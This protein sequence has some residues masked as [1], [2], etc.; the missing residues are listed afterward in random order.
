MAQDVQLNEQVII[1]VLDMHQKGHDFYIATN[2]E[3]IR[4]KKIIEKYPNLF[5]IFDHIFTSADLG[6][7][8]TEPAFFGRLLEIL[9]LR[10][11]DIVFIDD[12]QK[13][14]D[15]AQTTG[16]KTFKYTPGMKLSRLIKRL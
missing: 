15:A 1:W 2:Q 4:V 7:K 6:I 5:S 8:K 14:L 10:A 16:I 11:S 9:N 3:N 13:N 12:C